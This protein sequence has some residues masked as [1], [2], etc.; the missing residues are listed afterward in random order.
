M[1]IPVSILN[2]PPMTV[3]KWVAEKHDLAIDEVRSPDCRKH[4]AA[5]ARAEFVYVLRKGRA[6]SF[7]QIGRHISVNRNTALRMFQRH[8]QNSD[9]KNHHNLT[10]FDLVKQ[11]DIYSIRQCVPGSTP[12]HAVLLLVLANR[13]PRVTA[14]DPLEAAYFECAE[15]HNIKTNSTKSDE[16][17]KQL[18]YQIRKLFRE[19]G[20][21]DPVTTMRPAGYH[22]GH[23]AAVWLNNQIGI[24]AYPLFE[25]VL[26]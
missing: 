3:L 24:P 25:K 26:A 6:L 19:Q 23:E 7:G 12:G 17:V 22:L 8:K 13:Y 16:V 18:I 15:I 14:Y 10:A 4:K 2:A 20:L 5:R 9:K 21:P 1:Q 11:G